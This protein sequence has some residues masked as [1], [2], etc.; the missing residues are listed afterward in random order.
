MTGGGVGV[1][2]GGRVGGRGTLYL[3]ATFRATSRR[4]MVHRAS[5]SCCTVGLSL[6]LSHHSNIPVRQS[7]TR[8]GAPAWLAWMASS[9]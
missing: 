5:I 6:F 4:S 3:S 9:W 2:S 1:G 8:S 7:V